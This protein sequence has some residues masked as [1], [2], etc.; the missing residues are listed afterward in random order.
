MYARLVF[1]IRLF[2]SAHMPTSKTFFLYFIKLF[3]YE[4]NVTNFH[5]DGQ[6][7]LDYLVTGYV[8]K[9]TKTKKNKIKLEVSL[10]EATNTT[11]AKN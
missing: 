9:N 5:E 6:P 4:R 1:C 7:K 10:K 3:F 2:L 11:R 8:K